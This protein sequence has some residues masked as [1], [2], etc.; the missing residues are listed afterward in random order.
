MKKYKFVWKE[1]GQRHEVTIEAKHKE[2]VRNIFKQQR[3]ARIPL[4]YRF[5]EVK[6]DE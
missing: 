2:E 4:N 1:E 3:G 6:T 5:A